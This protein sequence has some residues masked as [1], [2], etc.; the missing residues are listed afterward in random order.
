MLSITV[1][2]LFAISTIALVVLVYN[3]VATGK[4]KRE[5]TTETT[6]Q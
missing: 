2:I 5:S 6:D 4:H 3:T 1:T